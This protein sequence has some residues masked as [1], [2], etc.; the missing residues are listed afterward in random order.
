MARRFYKRCLLWVLPFLVAQA[1]VPV[2]FMYSAGANGITVDFCPVQSSRIVDLLSRAETQAHHGAAHSGHHADH[3]DLQ[4][5]G[6]A[7]ASGSCPYA[8]TRTTISGAPALVLAPVAL[9][10]IGVFDAADLPILPS[11]P[12]T[13]I[14]IRGPPSILS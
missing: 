2:G 12:V 13:R 10:Q 6:D 4:G 1:L 5:D 14:R 8:L 9:V 11:A 7:A 3:G